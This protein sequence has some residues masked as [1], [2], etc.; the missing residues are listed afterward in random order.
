[1]PDR[2]S[3]VTW[4]VLHTYAELVK[5]HWPTLHPDMPG[6]VLCWPTMSEEELVRELERYVN[7]AS[8]PGCPVGLFW[9]LGPPLTYEGGNANFLAAAGVRSLRELV[10]RD[11]LDPRFPWGARRLRFQADD[12]RV[13]ETCVPFT[14][15]DRLVTEHGINWSRVAKAPIVTEDGTV[16][17]VFAMYETLDPDLGCKL[18]WEKVSAA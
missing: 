5:L 16:H 8:R 18:Y 15:I 2:S 4:A 7:E 3:G 10:G 1:M 17:G 12:R 6:R 13:L 14:Y 9:K 11:D